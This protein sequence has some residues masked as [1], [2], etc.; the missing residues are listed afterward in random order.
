MLRVYPCPV[1]F[2]M[3]RQGYKIHRG[4][5]EWGFLPCNEIWDMIFDTL[6]SAGGKASQ[7]AIAAAQA[8]YVFHIRLFF[9]RPI[10]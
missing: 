4:F 6:A 2:V 9:F 5:A 3:I 7:A 8:Q 1:Y 10:D